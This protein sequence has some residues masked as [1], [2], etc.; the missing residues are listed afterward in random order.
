M[1]LLPI[2]FI[3]SLLFVPK[4]QGS[5]YDI[6]E[7]RSFGIEKDTNSVTAIDSLALNL[8]FKEVSERS[9]DNEPPQPI[10]GAKYSFSDLRAIRLYDV[11]FVLSRVRGPY[12]CFIFN[13]IDS[14]FCVFDGDQSDFLNVFRPYLRR[15]IGDGRVMELLELYF[16]TRRTN[17]PCYILNTFADYAHIW[18]DF[19][20]NEL[21]K[22]MT[23]D[24]VVK[25]DVD[26]V[27]AL[28]PATKI[29]LRD[30]GYSME[31]WTWDKGSGDIEIWGIQ[32]SEKNMTITGPRTMMMDAGPSRLYIIGGRR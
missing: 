32:V 5:I 11:A 28:N 1:R 14:T 27:R 30:Y 23:P 19:L 24:S 31:V 13:A 16:Q 22:Y 8:L 6:L 15:I 26:R 29:T 9:I 25:I 17:N 7:A 10:I 2:L 18:D 4:A 20:S 3:I 21:G 12:D